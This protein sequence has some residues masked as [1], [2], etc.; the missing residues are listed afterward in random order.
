[1]LPTHSFNSCSTVK[2]STTYEE[3]GPARL[4]V[5][6]SHARH[7]G[8]TRPGFFFWRLAVDAQEFADDFNGQVGK[9]YCDVNGTIH[10]VVYVDHRTVNGQDALVI[11]LGDPVKTA[12]PTKHL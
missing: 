8:D 12:D 4:R 10:E 3:A 5:V 7:N 11:R 1:M 6:S 9:V 2:S